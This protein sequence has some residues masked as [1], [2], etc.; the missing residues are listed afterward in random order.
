MTPIE[1]ILEIPMITIYD[2]GQLE[3]VDPNPLESTSSAWRRRLE[4]SRENRRRRG[5]T[6]RR[7]HGK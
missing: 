2:S 5:E 6:Y 1:Q 4:W 7:R 3:P